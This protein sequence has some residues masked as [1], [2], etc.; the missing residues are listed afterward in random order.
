MLQ[1]RAK[2]WR[3]HELVRILS[4]GIGVGLVSAGILCAQTPQRPHIVGISHIA[5][6]AHDYERARVF[7][8][9]FLGFQEPYSLKNPDGSTIMTFFKINDRQYIELYPEHEANTDRMTHIS[10]E[11]D[12]I[13]ALRV[14]LASKGVEGSG[15]AT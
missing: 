4:R 11:T 2:R 10:L 5:L 9:E 3:F 8:G 6:L 13:E 12:D 7:Y 15:S 1:R 14:Y